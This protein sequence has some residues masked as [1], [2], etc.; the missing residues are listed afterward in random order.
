MS[1][2]HE[3]Y[4]FDKWF[5]QEKNVQ[6]AIEESGGTEIDVEKMLGNSDID[7]QSWKNILPEEVKLY[8][9]FNYSVEHK[10]GFFIANE[11]TSTISLF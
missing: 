7:A 5:V 11:T 9:K 2:Q 4:M 6:Q 1:E 3:K 8:R 10:Q